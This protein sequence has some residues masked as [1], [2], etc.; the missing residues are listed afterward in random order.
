MFWKAPVVTPNMKTPRGFRELTSVESLLGSEGDRFVIGSLFMAPDG[1]WHL[2]DPNASVRLS[3]PPD[4]SLPI[5]SLAFKCYFLFPSLF[6]VCPS[7]MIAL[8]DYSL[9]A[10]WSW[11]EFFHNF[12]TRAPSVPSFFCLFSFQSGNIRFQP[13]RG[14][15]PIPASVRAT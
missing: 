8:L 3:F 12:N 1:H 7:T 14:A 13:I 11:L 6:F 4:I 5:L 10:R 2:E 15:I 9:R